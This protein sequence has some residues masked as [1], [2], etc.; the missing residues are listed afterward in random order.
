[1]KR[2]IVGHKYKIQNV[3]LYLEYQGTDCMGNYCSLCGKYLKSGYSFADTMNGNPHTRII[4]G[5]ECIKKVL[6]K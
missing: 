1:M 2:L 5:T 4:Y 6:G 3:E